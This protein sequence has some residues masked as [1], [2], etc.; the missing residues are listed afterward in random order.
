MP[1]NP[2]FTPA[3]LAQLHLLVSQD[4]ESCRVELHHRSGISY[5]EYVT[6]R[7]GRS[8]ALLK[9]IDDALPSHGFVLDHQWGRELAPP[10]GANEPAA[11]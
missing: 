1:A 6:R 8:T 5:R 7:L 4:A 2:P 3:E 11:G 10:G 9:R